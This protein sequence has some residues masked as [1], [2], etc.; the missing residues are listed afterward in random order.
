MAD[1]KKDIESF[2]IGDSHRDGMSKPVETGAA[3]LADGPA[4]ESFSLGFAR[5]ENMLEKEDPSEVG[6]GLTEILGALENLLQGAET[7]KE[8][9]AIKRATAAVERAVDLMDYLF[10]TK[11]VMEDNI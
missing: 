4:A 5:I 9:L 10:Q 1:D 11:S 6:Q 8:K 7:N 3:R 2:K